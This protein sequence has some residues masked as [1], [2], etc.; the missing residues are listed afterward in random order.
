M[1]RLKLVQ[2]YLALQSEAA[3]L[4]LRSPHITSDMTDD[5]IIRRGLELAE[6]VNKAKSLVQDMTFVT[7]KA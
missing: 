5:E 3:R 2:R 6:R 4:G 7:S 1:N